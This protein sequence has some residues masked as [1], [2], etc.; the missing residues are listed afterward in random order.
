[1][2]PDTTRMR[3]AWGWCIAIPSS[4]TSPRAS[5]LRLVVSTEQLTNRQ[6]QLSAT[7]F[8]VALSPCRFQVCFPPS[9]CPRAPKL[10]RPSAAH[11]DHPAIRVQDK[12]VQPL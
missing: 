7:A 2:V 5:R 6:F 3:G 9:L 10:R 11:Y 12:V 8:C 4:E 1:M